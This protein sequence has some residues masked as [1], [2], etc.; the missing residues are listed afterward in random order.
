MSTDLPPGYRPSADEPYMNPRQLAYFREKLL[1]WRQELL[2]EAQATLDA[3]R[4]A[5]SDVADEAD[6]ATRESDTSLE[7]RTRDRYRKLQSKIDAAL[8]RIGDGSYGYCE[9]TGDEIGLARLEAR[10]IATLTV[11][12]QE[13]HERLSAQVADRRD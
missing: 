5:P 7:L 1:A 8:K 11:E 4:E 13:R 6:R 12:A 2:E 10:P 9:E 3:M